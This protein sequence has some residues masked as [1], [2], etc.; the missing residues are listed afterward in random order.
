MMDPHV[1]TMAPIKRLRRSTNSA[2]AS[3]SSS[4][5]RKDEPT[6]PRYAGTTSKILAPA[7]TS[8]GSTGST[9]LNS[10]VLVMTVITSVA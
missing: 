10:S 6:G 4:I 9:L 5:V 8:A 1:L 7:A 2:A 3:Y